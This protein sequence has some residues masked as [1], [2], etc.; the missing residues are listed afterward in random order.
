MKNREKIGL[1][2]L[3][4]VLSLASPETSSQGIPT[5]SLPRDPASITVYTIQNMHF[6][7]FTQGAIGGSVILSPEGTRTAT[8]DIVLLN[9]GTTF[10]QAIF[11]VDAIA[12]TV[13]SMVNGPNATLTGSNGGTM[14]MSI[15]SSS[16]VSP[17]VNVLQPP[18]R[19]PVYI[20][21]TLIVG[22]PASNPPGTYSGTFY[23]TFIQE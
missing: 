12:G 2:F 10:Y 13:I 20:G 16:P 23:I 6:G 1:I 19:T 3:T 14:S 4:A 5:D 15:G 21:A 18:S 9:M 8:G 7:A 17:F 22:S 11:E